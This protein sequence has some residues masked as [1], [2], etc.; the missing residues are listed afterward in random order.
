MPSDAAFYVVAAF[1]AVSVAGF[2]AAYAVLARV[3]RD[4]ADN[5]L[6]RHAMW[7]HLLL[8]TM[9]FAAAWRDGLLRGGPAD[10]GMRLP[11]VGGLG[12]TVST[13]L[14]VPAAAA[15]GAGLYGGEL[16][17]AAAAR[18]RRGGSAAD[19]APVDRARAAFDEERA[20]P[21][22][23][24]AAAAIVLA[25]EYIWRGYLTLYFS[26]RMGF[27]VVWA[28]VGASGLFGLHHAALGLRTCLAKML[29]GFAWCLM[30]VATG[31]LLP[32]V[33]SHLVF[34][35]AVWKRAGRAADAVSRPEAR[36]RR[37]R[38]PASPPRR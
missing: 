18:R 26:E 13:V 23:M 31:S 21:S 32:P 12:S 14:A 24:T 30:L 4:R 7:I 22:F 15:I 6:A 1:P 19:T 10:L 9:P 34:Q 35:Y 33:V 2:G 20:F 37:S 29:H 17:A 38:R 11:D 16:L 5:A 36:A 28:L 25:E 8:L 3:C 27:P